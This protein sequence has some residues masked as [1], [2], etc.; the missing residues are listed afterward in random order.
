M[1]MTDVKAQDLDAQRT[2]LIGRLYG[3][4]PS[5]AN[6]NRQAREDASHSL[7]VTWGLGERKRSH[8]SLMSR[9]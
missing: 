4:E 6:L 8:T 1:T 7:R 2:R 9:E 5:S 3:E